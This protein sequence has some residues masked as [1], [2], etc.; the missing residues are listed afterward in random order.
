MIRFGIGRVAWVALVV[1]SIAVP[2][3]AEIPDSVAE[4]YDLGFKL[5]T[6]DQ[7]FS[8]R[9]WGALQIRYTY[10]DYDERVEGNE[11][12]YSNFYLRRARVWF[13]GNAFDPRFTY[14]LHIQLEP[15]NGVNLHDAWLE[16]KFGDLL[17]L[18]AGRNKIPY[19][20]EFI[21]SGFGLQFVERSVFSGET[22]IDSSKGPVYPG[23]G[24][25]RFGLNA[26]APTGF[27]TG[28]MTLY[29]SQGVSLSGMRGGPDRASFEYQ[30][31]VWQ[32]R[33][34]TGQ[35]N[36]DDRHLFVARA[37]YHPWGFI[38]SRFQAD[39]EDTPTWRLGVI[40]SAYLN[41][42]V[43]GHAYHEQGYDLAVLNRYRGLSIDAEWAVESFDFDEFSSD[44]DREGW[45]VQAGYFLKPGKYELV[46]RYAEVERLKDPT[47]REAID[48]GLNVAQ[49]LD[50]GEYVPAI[51]AT[52]SELTAGA[53]WYI[54]EGH[55]HKLQ[56]DLSKLVRSFADDPGAV[57][58]G[59]PLPIVAMPDQE[60]WRVRIMVQL[61]F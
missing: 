18:G 20:V 60:D 6:A 37:G 7:R 19:G 10:L 32:G 24:T 46:A 35:S 39:L 17:N 23:G 12:D 36:V 53:N 50:G 14:Y 47:Y 61:V 31:G 22:D 2:A 16:Y 55:R 21:N 5:T 38:D 44:F 56:L 13:A 34:T 29:R 41:S 27:A 57:I 4:T 45:R 49:V 1:L 28:G 25:E 51:E 40:A 33:G 43:A 9:L 3:V 26:A 15:S 58:G 54:N 11:T 59:E 48:S 42:N 8:L 52:I 30:V